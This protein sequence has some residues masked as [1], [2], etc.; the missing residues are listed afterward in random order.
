MMYDEVY[1]TCSRC[2]EDWPPDG[3][4]YRRGKSKCRACE[5]EIKSSTPSRT[6]E[7]RLA[8]SRRRAAKK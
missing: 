1:K 7:A 2:K 8:E 6:P 5:Y 3:E 4:F